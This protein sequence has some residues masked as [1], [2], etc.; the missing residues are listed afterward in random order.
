MHI[1]LEQPVDQHRC[2]VKPLE[3]SQPRFLVGPLPATHLEHSA[4]PYVSNSSR[5][6]QV[7]KKGSADCSCIDFFGV[8]H[9]LTQRDADYHVD[10]PTSIAPK[11]LGA[12][13]YHHR[14]P[15][16]QRH[17]QQSHLVLGANQFDR[18]S[19]RADLDD[20]LKHP[21]DFRRPMAWLGRGE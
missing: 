15:A 7:A 2:L 13:A 4:R 16:N 9:E 3:H 8:P 10:R 18:N 11:T 14:L 6:C 17:A 21:K 19:L 1:R 12:L 5:S 20:C